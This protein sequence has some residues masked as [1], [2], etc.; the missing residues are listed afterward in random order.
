[1]K[2]IRIGLVG[3]GTVGSGLFNV[4]KY[5]GDIIA[6]RTGIRPVIRTICDIRRDH[7]QSQVGDIPVCD[8]WK[9][10]VV[11]PDIDIVVEL[12]GGIEPARSILVEAFKNGKDVVTANK[13]L[14]AEQGDAIFPALAA[15]GRRLGFEASVGGGIPCLLSLRQGLA[16]NRIKSVLGILNG[17]TNYILTR[18][19]D[20]DMPFDDALKLAQEK[21]FAEADP[22][23]DIEGYDA[24]H[25]IMLLAMLAYGKSMRYG[26]LPIEGITRLSRIDIA[27]A[28][29]MGYVI[30]LLGIAKDV[31]GKVDIRVHPTMIPERHPLASVR[32]EFNAVMFDGDMTGPVILYGRGAGSNPTAS[33][34]VSDILQISGGGIEGGTR[35]T[36]EPADLL[37]PGERLSRYYLRLHT[38]DR[39]GILSQISGVLG[40]HAISISSV[41][42][43]EEHGEHVPL[44]FMSHLA[45]EDRVRS[46]IGEIKG[47]PFVHGDVMLIRVEDAI[48][49]GGAA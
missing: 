13:K 19:E 34:V 6:E 18:M 26:D 22:T 10:V 14:L 2:S 44:I 39:P 25:K 47:F 23:F 29:D 1:M 9:K 43:K 32:D 27:Y 49:V 33:A 40:N 38:D 20:S 46:A 21:G 12:I 42:Q 24:G 17:T 16:G 4:L 41:M 3:F 36:S 37:L 31:G 28:R 30:K 5:N 48:G 35:L 15:S 11:D 7:V 8:D 45:R